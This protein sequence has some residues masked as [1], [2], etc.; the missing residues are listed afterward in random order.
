[1]HTQMPKHVC[2]CHVFTFFFSIIYRDRERMCVCMCVCVNALILC[3]PTT[4]AHKAFQ[5]LQYHWQEY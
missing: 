5:S 4:V 3:D 1:M 2:V